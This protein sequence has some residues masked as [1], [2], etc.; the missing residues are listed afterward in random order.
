M[1]YKTLFCIQSLYSDK[2]E[3]ICIKLLGYFFYILKFDWILYTVPEADFLSGSIFS[4]QLDVALVKNIPGVYS[5]SRQAE[6][7]FRDVSEIRNAWWN[8]MH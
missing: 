5:P 6:S 7:C 8:H 4:V 3:R 1:D 2:H